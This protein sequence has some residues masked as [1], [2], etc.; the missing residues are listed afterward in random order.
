MDCVV[1]R[2]ICGISDSRIAVEEIHPLEHG[3]D[4]RA[5]LCGAVPALWPVCALE[6]VEEMFAGFTGCDL[7]R[8]SGRLC[9]Q[10]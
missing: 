8:I 2:G 1:W 7:H 3:A 5:V 4:R 10:S 6:A 9:G